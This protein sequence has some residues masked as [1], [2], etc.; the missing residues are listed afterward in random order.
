MTAPTPTKGVIS[1]AYLYLRSIT[2]SY[3]VTAEEEVLQHIGATKKKVDVFSLDVNK[4]KSS[5][6]VLPHTLYYVISNSAGAI[7]KHAVKRRR[8]IV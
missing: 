1:P 5:H 6:E 7:R 3:S 8:L 2:L 4:K